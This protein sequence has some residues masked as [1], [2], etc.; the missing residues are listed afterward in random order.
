M[1][2][3]LFQTDTVYHVGYLDS[4]GKGPLSFEGHGL[5]VSH[6]PAAWRSI[7]RLGGR[8]LH[9]MTFK[10]AAYF[11]FYQARLPLLATIR[12]WAHQNGFLKTVEHWKGWEWDGESREWRFCL[13]E[14][15]D[16]AVYELESAWDA[17]KPGEQGLQ[18]AFE[19]LDDDD[20]ASF[21]Q[22]APGLLHP[23]DIPILGPAGIARAP[24]FPNNHD[25]TDIAALFWIEDEIRKTRPEIVGT[26]WHETFDPCMLSAPRGAIIPSC[27]PFFETTEIPENSTGPFDEEY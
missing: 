6:C 26:W 5:S 10:G 8:P 21:P 4:A 19:R 18:A 20:K 12:S 1:H 3:P 22:E 27:I 15:R 9:E 2:I 16:E 7:A 17:E 24:S 11:D 13:Y 25:A 14:T 23:V